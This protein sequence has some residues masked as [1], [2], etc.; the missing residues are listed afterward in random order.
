MNDDNR[1]RRSDIT[2]PHRSAKKAQKAVPVPT[3]SGMAIIKK[4][5]MSFEQYVKLEP[6][7]SVRGNVK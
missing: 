7:Y 6:S 4:L 5:E 1:P 2:D 3:H